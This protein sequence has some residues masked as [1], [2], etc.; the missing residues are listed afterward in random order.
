MSPIQLIAIGY[1]HHNGIITD[2]EIKS[3]KG[4]VGYI[5]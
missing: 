4:K 5:I 2:Y 3:K 1:L